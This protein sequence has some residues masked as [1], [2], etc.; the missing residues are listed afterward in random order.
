MLDTIRAYALERLTA[1]GEEADA[2]HAHAMHFLAL[3]EAAE[4]A[5]I[6]PN[7]ERWLARLAAEQDNLRSAL[8]WLQAAGQAES[9]LRLAG[10][11]TFYWFVRGHFQEGGAWLERALEQGGT[12]PDAARAKALC[13]L[14]LLSMWRA[15]DRPAA[16]FGEGLALWR[17]LGNRQGECFGL[18]GLANAALFQGDPARAEQLLLQALA[19]A[20]ELG[21]SV[22][23]LELRCATLEGLGCTSY[24]SGDRVLAAHRFG[25]VLA[26]CRDLG[27]M[28]ATTSALLGLAFVAHDEGDQVRALDLFHQS[29]DIACTYGDQRAIACALAGV[30]TVA[31]ASGQ[32]EP[33]A[34]LFGATAALRD[35]IGMPNAAIFP[36]YRA[37]ADRGLSAVQGGLAEVAYASALAAGR[38]LPVDRAVAEANEVEPPDSQAPVIN[39]AASGRGLTGREV[40]VL[41]LLVQHRTDREIGEALFVSPRTVGWHVTHI[42]SKLGVDSRRA[43][44]AVALHENLV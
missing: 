42:L 33:A 32:L 23:A 25:E 20:G 28:W 35:A 34:R 9:V 10:A 4:L 2:H 6:L 44:A 24:V 27:D 22:V 13:G 37:A 38:A 16:S 3:A 15:D 26:R 19:V 30:A 17:S 29:L 21:S 18:I 43:A 39:P 40:E 8:A 5:V 14:G 1:S 11:L 36:P 31:A 12:A 41:R 7:D